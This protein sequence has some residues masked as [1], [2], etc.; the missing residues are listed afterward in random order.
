MQ[1]K[2]TKILIILLIC[3]VFFGLI[4]IS[5]FE[6]DS[7]QKNEQMPLVLLQLQH[8]N[9][10]GQLVSYV[11]GTKIIS[12][13]PKL[14]NEFL[15][16]LPN[17]KTIIKDGEKFELFQWIGP[18][19]KYG[20]VHSWSAM[21]LRVLPVNGNYRTVLMVLYNAFQTEPGDTATIH[22]TVLRPV[23]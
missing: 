9:S 20:K 11:E 15:D 19:E 21:E 13:K 3:V 17:K 6:F 23:D 4:G 8:R 12:I 10:D 16:K 14:L 7:K 18:D 1:G 2:Y 22:W 5:Y